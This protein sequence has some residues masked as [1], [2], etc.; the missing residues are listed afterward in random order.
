MSS[1]KRKLEGNQC[2]NK[3]FF[4]LLLQEIGIRSSH[5]TWGGKKFTN[6]VIL[7][8]EK[9]W[10]LICVCFH[11]R[12]TF[13]QHWDMGS[14]RHHTYVK[15]FRSLFLKSHSYEQ[16]FWLGEGS[17]LVEKLAYY[18]FQL[19]NQ[20]LHCWRVFYSKKTKVKISDF[21]YTCK[22]YCMIRFPRWSNK[23]IRA[24][25][26]L[27]RT[28]PC[29]VDYKVIKLFNLETEFAP[30]KLKALEI[31]HWN[32][33]NWRVEA[34]EMCAKVST[35]SKTASYVCVNKWW[36]KGVFKSRWWI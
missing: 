17:F 13:W 20:K 15:F 14:S 5:I 34:G 27:R 3:T 12:Y 1:G 6:T 16:F 2:V 4:Q 23:M 25:F 32:E 31:F 28:S 33:C 26:K 24:I 29:V 30:R 10:W 19:R 22:W 7:L 21:L 8:F 35:V 36:Q 18:S 9:I 11:Y